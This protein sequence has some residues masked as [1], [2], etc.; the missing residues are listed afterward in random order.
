M[1]QFIGKALCALF[2]V[3][4]FTTNA[5][6]KTKIFTNGIP[7]KLIPLSEVQKPEKIDY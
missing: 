6:V 7:L 1:K 5:Q 2:M 4:S 3:L